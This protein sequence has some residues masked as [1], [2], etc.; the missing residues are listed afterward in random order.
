MTTIRETLWLPDVLKNRMVS[1]AAT[2]I[3]GPR[4]GAKTA[5][6]AIP[7]PLPPALPGLDATVA[8]VESLPPGVEEPFADGP[9]AFIRWAEHVEGSA[10]VL[11]ATEAGRPVLIGSAHLRYLAGWPDRAGWDRI[12]DLAASEAGLDTVALPDGLRLRDTSTH[13][14]AF[15]YAATTIEW[16]GQ[17]I[18]PAGIHWWAREKG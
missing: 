4:S 14:F 5:D 1:S 8:L 17:S 13:R 10:E 11:V 2:V 3:V 9:G 12:V 6:G 7:V 15:N 18:P 16:M